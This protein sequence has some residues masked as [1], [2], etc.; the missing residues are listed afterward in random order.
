MY[1]VIIIGAGPGGIF[2]A[3]EL[4]TMCLPSLPD[5]AFAALDS[6]PGAIFSAFPPVWW[7]SCCVGRTAPSP[8][9]GIS[10]FAPFPLNE[11][12]LREF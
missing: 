4:I 5:R 10:G 8:Q 11:G 7:V 3:Y 6:A 2:S 9:C 12:D 1:D